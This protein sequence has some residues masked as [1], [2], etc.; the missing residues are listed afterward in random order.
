MTNREAVLAVAGTSVSDNSIDKALTDIGLTPSGYY[1][2]TNASKIDLATIEV[3]KS[4]IATADISEGG[5]SIKYD[6]SAILKRITELGIK[7][8]LPEYT[9]RPTVRS[10]NVW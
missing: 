7:N 1:T 5:Y 2:L 6:R 9:A 10:V 8:G 4:I 3:L